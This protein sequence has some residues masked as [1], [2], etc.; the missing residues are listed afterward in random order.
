MIGFDFTTVENGHACEIL[1]T[2]TKSAASK[3]S[4]TSQA[5]IAD[6]YGIIHI[7][8]VFMPGGI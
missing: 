3:E 7:D 4:V 8:M 1:E 6:R 2:P 5:V